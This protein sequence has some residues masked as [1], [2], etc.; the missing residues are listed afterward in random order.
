MATLAVQVKPRSGPLSAEQRGHM[1]SQKVRLGE[2]TRARQCLTG[3]PLAPGFDDTL[4]ELQ[5]K[6]AQEVVRELPE[7]VRALVLE[8]PLVVSK[9]ILLK[10]LKS[11]PRGSS[12]GPGGCTYQHLK[13]LI[14]D[15]DTFELLCE[16]VTSLAQ[17]RVPASMSKALTL[18]RPTSFTKKD[19]GV[20][21]IS[22]GCSLRRLTAET[23]AKQVV[24][25]FES[26]RSSTRCPPERALIAWAICCVQPATSAN[27][28]AT[29]LS[30]DGVGAYDHVLRAAMLGRF[31]RMPNAKALLPFL[32][33]S[34]SA[35]STYDWYDDEGERKTVTQAE[36]GEQGDPPMPLLFSIGIQSA[37]E[38]VCRS[39]LAGE[40]LCAFLDDLY[41][42][43]APRRVRHLFDL[44]L[45]RNVGIQLHQGKTC[46][47]NRSGTVPENVDSLVEE[48]WRTDGIKVLGTPLGKPH[49][50]AEHMQKRLEEEQRLWD[51]ISSFP[52]LQCAWQILVQSA[53]P[54]ANH[55]IRTLPLRL[56]QEYA[57]GHDKG[58]WDTAK[59]LL[60][61][62]PGSDEEL[63]SAEM[64]ARLPMR[65][66]GLGYGGRQ[67]DALTP[68][69]GRHGKMPWRPT[70]ARSS[71]HCRTHHGTGGTSNW[72]FVRSA[73]C[74]PTTGQRGVLVASKL[75][76][77]TRWT[78]SEQQWGTKRVA[79][80]VSVLGF[81]HF[82][83][84]L[85]VELSL[86]SSRAA[87]S[88]AHLRSHSG[89]N[90]GA[91]SP[92][93]P[94]PRSTQSRHTCLLLLERLQLPLPVTEATCAL[95][96]GGSTE[97][98]AHSVDA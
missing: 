2:I 17:A 30:V 79:T 35:L 49:F 84:L 28:D 75:D 27:P 72:L 14:D 71:R 8:T 6:R 60:K 64:V 44:A 52:D 38:E 25:D 20:R 80:R 83:H 42:L 77:P 46:V 48:V 95:T 53:N 12:P 5:R 73:G 51:A 33:L 26:D 7:H 24:K 68:R 4:N 85:P 3:A 98:L 93:L 91:A 58:M 66:G 78:S 47:W 81:F 74:V 63:M 22:T 50:V 19:G 36:G 62:L 94:R 97:L 13:V 40:R 69:I 10:S 92:M 86:L 31:A 87:A 88:R 55:T 67:S 29:V 11:S 41:L 1:A 70:N 16:A 59:G 39:L 96:S 21:R 90:A 9:E 61:E 34:Y 32:L 43:C 76:G 56:S 89:C 54:R 18:A 82:G 15:V 23:L 37:V 57:R 65:M 45:H